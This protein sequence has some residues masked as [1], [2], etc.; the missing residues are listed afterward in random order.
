MTDD[1]N[2]SLSLSLHKTSHLFCRLDK[3]LMCY[4]LC[5]F[6]SV[7]LQSGFLFSTFCH[8]LLLFFSRFCLSVLGSALSAHFYSPHLSVSAVD[9]LITPSVLT[10]LCLCLVSFEILMSSESKYAINVH[11]HKSNQMCYTK[12]K[13]RTFNNSMSEIK[14]S[15]GP[16]TSHR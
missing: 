8:I 6:S 10:S 2:L 15:S 3:V 13:M 4:C 11:V 9:V 12:K 1:R 16:N 14:L 7:F 5:V